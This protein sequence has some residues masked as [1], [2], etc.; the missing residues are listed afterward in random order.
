M[1]ALTGSNL[2]FQDVALGRRPFAWKLLKTNRESLPE[3]FILF[4]KLPEIPKRCVPWTWVR[5]PDVLE[6]LSHL[7]P[8]TEPVKWRESGL[9]N[10]THACRT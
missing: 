3:P 2:E 10:S 4:S 1:T 9:G 7:R 6:S 8:V 5:I